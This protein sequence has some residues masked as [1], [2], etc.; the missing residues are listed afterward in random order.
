MLLAYR[1]D[2]PRDNA[3]DLHPRFFQI[4][5]GTEFVVAEIVVDG[6]SSGEMFATGDFNLDGI[7]DL[8]ALPTKTIK[9]I[10]G[11]VVDSNMCFFQGSTVAGRLIIIL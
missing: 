9:T 5:G 3:E 11:D 1:V 8:V 2:D 4:L 6:C 7:Q 10:S